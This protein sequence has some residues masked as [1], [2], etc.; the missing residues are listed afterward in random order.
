MSGVG[1]MAHSYGGTDEA[2]VIP[3]LLI[4]KAL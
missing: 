4:V 3:K 1:G 2:K